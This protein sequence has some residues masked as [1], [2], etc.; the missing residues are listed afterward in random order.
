VNYGGSTAA[1]AGG[2][3]AAQLRYEE[4]DAEGAL[5]DLEALQSA[6]R[7]TEYNLATLEAMQEIYQDLGLTDHILTMGKEIVEQTQAPDV[8]ARTAIS[9]MD[10]GDLE[11]AQQAIEK[12]DFAHLQKPLAFE[13]LM[14]EG[15]A[16]LA[17]APQR[18][19][20]KMEEAHFNYPEARTRDADQQLLRTYL[21]T[22]RPA[23]ARRMVMELKAGAEQKASDAPYLVDAAIA[24]GDYLYAQEDY[25][26]AE[27]AYSMAEEAGSKAGD[28]V[29]GLRS[30]PDWAQYQ[31]ANA[32]L[33][34]G[35]YEGCLALYEKIGASD[36]PWAGE[37]SV[38][39]GLAR[40]E[41]RQRG[42]DVPLPPQA[43]AQN[44]AQAG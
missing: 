1:L 17:V 7:G 34:L 42:I 5:D 31:R 18:G 25:R 10:A 8:L 3:E 19:L 13:L 26:T 11:S 36:S 30:H 29:A 32:L 2:I 35:D 20:E 22:G 24:W 21:A 23:A 41:Q 14:K 16:L 6:T 44:T 40:L 43:Q 12:I 27:F 33:N 28:K 9:L 38:K 37:A 4:G 39:A 15:N